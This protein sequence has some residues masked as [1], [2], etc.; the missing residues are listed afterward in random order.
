[1]ATITAKSFATTT[2]F[3]G[4]AVTISRSML[5]RLGKGDKRI[6]LNHIAGVRWKSAGLQYGYI[7]FTVPG[8]VT[9]KTKAGSQLRDA[10]KDENAVLFWR[11]KDE[12]A[13]LRAAVEE[14]LDGRESGSLP[15]SV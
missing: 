3:D 2:T 9:R 8:E 14:A 6:P 13:A 12:F 15:G 4:H 5:N 7:Q 10:R 11:H 1:M